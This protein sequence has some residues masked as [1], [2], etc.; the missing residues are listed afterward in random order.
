MVGG[1]GG[2]A[3]ETLGSYRQ[4]GAGAVICYAFFESELGTGLIAA[5]AQLAAGSGAAGAVRAVAGACAA[6]AGGGVARKAALLEREQQ[7]RLE[8]VGRGS[9]QG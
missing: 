3:T 8:A 5:T 9:E 2:A 7:G 6:T 4:G 1:G